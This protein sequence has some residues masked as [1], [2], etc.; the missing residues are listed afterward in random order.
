MRLATVAAALAI[1]W[2]TAVSAQSMQLEAAETWRY[3][4][5][6]YLYLPSLGGKS[7]V[8]ADSGGT[9]INVDADRILDNLRGTFMG[10]RPR[11]GRWGA[12][13]DFIY[14]DFSHEGGSRD[15]TIGDIGLP[16]GRP[17]LDWSLK[18][19][20]W[21]VAGQYRV[22]CSRLHRRRAFGTRLLDIRTT[23]KW[24]IAGSI[25]PIAPSG[26]R[27]ERNQALELGRDR[28]RKGRYVFGDSG[29]GRC[30]TKVDVGAGESKLT[31]QAAAGIS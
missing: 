19:V 18:G 24:D 11:N 10:A 16:V 9:P 5:T 3:S 1:N 25:G 14:L 20:A 29:S 7:S 30:A 26:H 31:W 28:R 27:I 4:A 15:F 22:I 2:P 17:N 23:L 12:F 21:T 6:I 13:T 8:P